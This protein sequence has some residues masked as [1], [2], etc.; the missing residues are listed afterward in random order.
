MVEKGT[1][2]MIYPTVC[3][4]FTVADGIIPDLIINPHCIPSRM[5]IAHLMETLLGKLCA[6]EGRIGSGT[7]FRYTSIQEIADALQKHKT[8][9]YGNEGMINGMTAN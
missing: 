5:T 6:F 3:M 7:P 4:P 1:C 2:G 9:P 8:H